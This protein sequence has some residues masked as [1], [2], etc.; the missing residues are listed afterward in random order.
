MTYRAR[1]EGRRG[2][3]M[4]PFEHPVFV[5]MVRWW[6]LYTTYAPHWSRIALRFGWI[7]EQQ[8]IEFTDDNV[9]TNEWPCPS[10]LPGRPA[11]SLCPCAAWPCLCACH[12]DKDESRYHGVWRQ[13]HHGRIRKGGEV[14]NSEFVKRVAELQEEESRA[15]EGWWWLSFCN[16]ELLEGRRFLGACIVKGRGILSASSAARA[17]GCNPGGEIK[18]VGPMSLDTPF[19]EGWTERLLTREECGELERIMELLE[20]N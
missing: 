1:S 15:P 9:Q 19:P 4:R 6:S 3:T 5:A 8:F 20:S 17:L 10:M 12:E 16:A 18:G 14:T 2:Q 7:T 11:D 13:Y